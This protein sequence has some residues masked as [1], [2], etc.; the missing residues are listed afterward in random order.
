MDFNIFMKPSDGYENKGDRVVKLIKSVYGPK[1]A[2]RRKD[3]KRL[4]DI[5]VSKVGME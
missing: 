5:P 2:G 4:G 3:V 1:Q